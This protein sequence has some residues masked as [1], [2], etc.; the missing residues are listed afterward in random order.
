[1]HDSVRDIWIAFNEPLEARLDFMY[2]DVRGLAT[3]GLGNLIDATKLRRNEPP[4]PPTDAERADSWVIA[5]RLRWLTAADELATDDQIDAEWDQIRAR[6]EQAK[7]GG[8]T[9]RQFATLHLP[10]D[11]IDRLVFDK[12]DEMEG[13]LRR[14]KPFADFDLLPADAQLGLLSMAWGMG[15]MF[16]FPNFQGHVAAGRWDDAATE[17]R[18]NPDKGT[19]RIRNDRNQQLFRNAGIVVDA[20][21]D[22]SNLLWSGD[23]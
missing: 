22:P 12:L 11:E 1:M 23:Q 3:T 18:F 16:N 21:L 7:R 4:R 9:F 6:L 20:G 2:L 8:G 5:R 17:C 13:T 19:I 10:D 14:R 15:P